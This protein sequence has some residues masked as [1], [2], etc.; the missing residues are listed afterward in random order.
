[1]KNLKN[2]E[3]FYFLKTKISNKVNDYNKS[4]FFN[5]LYK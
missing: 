4:L 2:I 3:T 5:V 1:M